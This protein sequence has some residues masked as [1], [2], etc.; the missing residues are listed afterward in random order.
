VITLDDSHDPG[1]RSWVDSANK[2]YND[3]PI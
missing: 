2:A 1:P 3:F